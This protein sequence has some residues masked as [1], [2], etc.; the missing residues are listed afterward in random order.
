MTVKKYTEVIEKI[1][2][3]INKYTLD[4]SELIKIGSTAEKGDI[5]LTKYDNSRYDISYYDSEQPDPFVIKSYLLNNNNYDTTHLYPSYV[6]IP[7]KPSDTFLLFTGT[8]NKNSIIVTNHDKDHY[9]VYNDCRMN[10]SILYDDVV[11][12]ADYQD[13]KIKNSTNGN[14]TAYMQFVN[15]D[16]QLVVQKQEVKDFK[17]ER[18]SFAI[19]GGNRI[20]KYIPN[21]KMDSINKNKFENTREN[22]HVKILS[23]AKKFNC[24]YVDEKGNNIFETERKLDSAKAWH[25]FITSIS[26]KINNHVKMLKNFQE[27]WQKQLQELNRKINKTIDDKVKIK[28]LTRKLAQSDIQISLYHNHYNRILLEGNQIERSKL[29]WEIK[30]SKGMNAV[31]KNKE[32]SIYGGIN[33]YKQTINERYENLVFVHKNSNKPSF[34]NSFSEGMNG[35]LEVNISGLKKNMTSIE[36]KKLYLTQDLSPIERGALYQRINNVGHAEYIKYILNETGKVSELFYSLN[37]Q[38]NRLMPQ[39]F[40]LTLI[41]DD[42]RGRCYPLV[43][44]MSVALAKNDQKGADTLFNKL[45]IASANPKDND[46]ILIKTALERLHSNVEAIEA[47]FSHGRINI[48]ET[49]NLLEAKQ[50]TMMF[51]IN[52]QNHSMLIGKTINDKKSHYYF[53]DPNFGLFSFNNSKELFSAFKKFMVDNKM[54]DFYSAFGSNK[55]P[56]F[57]VISIITDDMSSVPVGSGLSVTHLSEPISL[58]LITKRES[59]T[60]SIVNKQL[61]I[62]RDIQLKGTL[63]MLEAQQWGYRLETSL[64][65][66]SMNYQFNRKWV[67]I[68]STLKEDEKGKYQL[69]FIDYDDPEKSHWIEMDDPTIKE[70]NHYYEKQV[71]L[72]RE[73]YFFDGKKIKPQKYIDNNSEY[74]INEPSFD[75]LNAGIAIQSLMLW[76]SDKNHNRNGMNNDNFNVALAL[77]I[78]SYINYGMIFHG[79]MNDLAK[80]V[81]IIRSGLNENISYEAKNISLFSTSLA[82]T[83]NEGVTVLFN[84]TLVGFDIYE[85]TYAKDEPH[86]IIFS[87]QLAF[88]SASFV[89]GGLSLGTGALGVT[90]VSVFMGGAG[91][92]FAGLSIG[93]TGLARNYAVIGEDAKSV[94]RY[95]YQ[96][97]QAYKNNGYDYLPDKSIALPRAGAV[98]KTIDLRNNQIEFDSQYIY[99]T[100]AH[101]AGGGRKNYIFWAG[102]FPTM[103]HDRQQAINIRKGIGYNMSSRQY[104]YLDAQIIALP[105]TPKSYI[106]YDYNLWPGATT[107]HDSGFD[108][109]RRLENTDKFDYD[110]YIFPSENTITQI[111]HEYVDTEIE[112]KLNNQYRHLVIP[113]IPSEWHGKIK[114]SIRGDGGVYKLSP[115]IGAEIELIDDSNKV[116]PSHWIISGGLLDK[117]DII[118]SSDCINI[119]G[120]KIKIDQSV[121]KKDFLYINNNNEVYKVD[122]L[123]LDLNLIGED[124]NKWVGHNEELS[125]HLNKLNEQHKIMGQY[126]LIENY[127]Y[128]KVNVGRAFYQVST[129]RYI[130]TDSLEQYTKNADLFSLLGAGACFYSKDN[131][132]LW[133]VDKDNK[134]QWKYIINNNSQRGFELTKLWVSNENIYF[135]CRYPSEGAHEVANYMINGDEIILVSVSIDE[136]THYQLFEEKSVLPKDISDV[137]FGKYLLLVDKVKDK[138][139]IYSKSVKLADIIQISGIDKNNNIYHYWLRERDGVIIKPNVASY[140]LALDNKE[141]FEPK[142]LMFVGFLLNNDGKEVFFFYSHKEKL[143]Y[144]QVG[145]NPNF[146]QIE[147]QEIKRI[148]AENIESVIFSQSKI[149]IISNNGIVS[150]INAQGNI[151][152]V[153]LNQKWFDSHST[154]WWEDFGQLESNQGVYALLG[155]KMSDNQAIIPAW[156]ENKSIVIAYQLSSKNTL[157]YLGID[158]YRSAAI[159]FDMENKKLYWQPIVNEAALVKA[160]DKNNLKNTLSLPSMYEIYPNIKFD[161]VKKLKNGLLMYTTNDE[162]L[163]YSK[164]ENNSDS[165]KE[166]F[167]SSLL[168]NG[169]NSRDIINPPVINNVKN[170]ILSA[171]DKEDSYVISRTA[172]LHY[173]AIIIDNNA[174]DRL[175]DTLVLPVDDMNSLAVNRLGDDLI[176]TDI[177][178]NSILIIRRIFAANAQGYEHLQLR[179]LNSNEDIGVKTIV[180]NYLLTDGLMVTNTPNESDEEILLAHDNQLAQL[181]AMTS[182]LNHRESMIIHQDIIQPSLVTAPVLVG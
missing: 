138:K 139:T 143:I 20:L 177:N 18:K 100:S 161:T 135:S 150:Q 27:V 119:G 123:N 129:G 7:K 148:E 114:H 58:S 146:F 75:G 33:E 133:L 92:I 35:F 70:F 50:K 122:F 76:Y 93:V 116:S 109:I 29:W 151:Q 34:R 13:Y 51:A 32:Q 15:N 178:T 142:D 164:G 82:Q 41:G 182:S 3:I 54:A 19:E 167:S 91:V 127:E 181:S 136:L 166:E 118:V 38:I 128:G 171:G 121:S 103:V 149:L 40:Y 9:R 25:E 46:S 173:Q 175:T 48:K 11:M 31:V 145:E 94:G 36:L 101:S 21:N 52:S 8:L 77:K 174:S 1:N 45:Y 125:N 68:F 147:K 12:S 10:S 2:E 163:Y 106:K 141:L 64:A 87:T 134:L 90:E 126:V 61:A 37:S 16:W 81:G 104:G 159:I 172:W 26:I 99:R 62:Q 160:F 57:E 56:V 22:I 124:G 165:N 42:S 176:L 24:L 97:D 131:N 137:I 17:G 67:P 14:A 44:A 23:I 79:A 6:D 112:I 169:G 180:D 102:N 130:F 144:R 53:Y 73:N 65:N 179:F 39:D 43:R 47:S 49:Q 132:L 120:V 105:I 110:F 96:L 28:S 155:L 4:T 156:Y 115:Q 86:K 55:D 88:D 89:T 80:I 107:R 63:A 59:K 60:S 95:F 85:L 66:L 71:A 72:F 108:V 74:N 113:K 30:K 117:D 69:Q 153:A 83:V 5:T 154:R 140:N 84:G 98:F 170:I 168:I 78:H 152:P 158:E 157:Q 162:I 111:F